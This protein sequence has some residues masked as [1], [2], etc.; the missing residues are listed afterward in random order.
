MNGTL[1]LLVNH[2]EIYTIMTREQEGENVAGKLGAAGRV[3]AAATTSERS[4]GEVGLI[5][6]LFHAPNFVTLLSFNYS[7]MYGG[8]GSAAQSNVCKMMGTHSYL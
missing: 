4:G 6:Q 2:S 8:R 3:A 5:F 1:P 7:I